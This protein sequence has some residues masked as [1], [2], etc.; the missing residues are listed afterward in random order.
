MKPNVAQR[1]PISYLK[2]RLSYSPETGDFFWIAPPITGPAKNGGKA[3]YAK[4][5]GYVRIMIDQL[6]YY[7]HHLAWAFTTG[8]WP[9]NEL[10]H[11]DRDRLNNRFDN[12][13]DV[14]R[15]QN[16]KNRKGMTSLRG[17]TPGRNGRWRAQIKVDYQTIHIG[18]Y[19]T[20]E[21]AHAAYVK[22]AIEL[23][24]EYAGVLND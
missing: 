16:G 21:E 24:G 17:T 8:A 18:T 11:I 6:S 15:K 12:L 10:D 1:A 20:R 14:T 4:S 13:R 2:T 22:K 19:D 3:G 7:A 5:G 23:F 9:E